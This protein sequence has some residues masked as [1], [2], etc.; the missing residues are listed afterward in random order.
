MRIDANLTK[1][2][3]V[4]REFVVSVATRRYPDR[5]HFDIAWLVARTALDN[6][7]PLM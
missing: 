1:G 6:L 7:H 5:R 4:G 2:Q 3:M